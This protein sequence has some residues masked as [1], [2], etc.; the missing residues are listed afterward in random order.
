MKNAD[1]HTD[2]TLLEINISTRIKE[3]AVEHGLQLPQTQEEVA[4]FEERYTHEIQKANI[5]PPPLK[6]ILALAKQID[7]SDES[8][9]TS[10]VGDPIEYRYAMAARNGKEI[11]SEIE[12]R[13]EE[14]LGKVKSEKKT[15]E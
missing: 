9:V 12:E 7:T 4:L 11:T 8:I 2:K 13:M 1:K 15:D 10:Q 6:V 14:A 5:N 3:I